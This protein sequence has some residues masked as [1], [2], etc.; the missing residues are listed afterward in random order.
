M[1][2]ELREAF[3]AIGG[4]PQHGRQA[5][6]FGGGQVLGVL[7]GCGCLKQ[8]RLLR[9]DVVLELRLFL[10]DPGGLPVQM[11]RIAA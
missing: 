9:Q 5:F 6:V 11:V 8:A 3:T 7:F 4:C 1:T 10:P 2:D